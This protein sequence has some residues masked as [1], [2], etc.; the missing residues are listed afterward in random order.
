MLLHDT[1]DVLMELAK[2][3]NYCKCGLA[4]NSTFAV[5]T[6][7]WAVLRLFCF[8]YFIVRS[9][10][11]EVQEVLGFRPPFF[12]LFNVLFV[13]LYC[14]H[15]Y[16]FGLILRIVRISLRT[17]GAKDIREDDDDDDS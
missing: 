7:S 11:F 1:T 5:F 4:A 15:L 8:P 9:T 14:M 16:W 17:G 10:M 6:V 3:F 2:I 12:W 13:A